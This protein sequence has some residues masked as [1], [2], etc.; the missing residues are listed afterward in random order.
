ML[1]YCRWYMFMK[2]MLSFVLFCF[3]VRFVEI[4]TLVF[5]GF[6]KLSN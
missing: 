5:G 6:E 4:F 2:I 3:G 1:L